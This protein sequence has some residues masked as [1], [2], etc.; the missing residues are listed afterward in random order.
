[1]ANREIVLVPS[2]CVIHNLSETLVE[3][4]DAVGK[5]EDILLF[6]NTEGPCLESLTYRKNSNL[7]SLLEKI[8]KLNNYDPHRIKI[9]T[10]NLIQKKVWPNIEKILTSEGW[11]F[12][13]H[14]KPP[15]Q[16]KNFKYHFGNFVSNSTWP[17]LLIASHLFD[18]HKDKTFQ[19]YRRNPRDPGQS[20]DLDLDQ[21]MFNCADPSVLKKIT[22]FLQNLP[23]EK[24]KNLKEHP[25]ANLEAGKDGDA[26]NKTIMSW[27]QNFFCD[28]VTET[29]FTGTTFFP[30]EKTTRPLI[31]GNPFLIHGP[32]DFLSNLKKL[33][34]KTF[35]EFWDE[36]YDK[37]HGYARYLMICEVIDDLSKLDNDQLNELYFKMSPIIEHNQKRIQSLTANDFD[38]F[39]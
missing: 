28:I 30:T 11:F 10:G 33:G 1:M 4:S 6:L 22:V 31:C 15:K 35:N 37:W 17:R 34:F 21:L 18:Q 16:E 9:Y 27:Y 13:D 36:S 39:F 2:D 25:Q 32:V 23:I 38:I 5:N 26:V 29:F 14:L 20:V 12:G 19:T 8:C 7:I 24:E 3:I